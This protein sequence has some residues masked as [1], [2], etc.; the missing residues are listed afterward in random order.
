MDP[1]RNAKDLKKCTRCDNAFFCDRDCQIAAWKGTKLTTGM[2]P[3]K[4]NC[5][6]MRDGLLARGDYGDK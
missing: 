5:K 3:H 2:E 6:Q 1:G 4:D